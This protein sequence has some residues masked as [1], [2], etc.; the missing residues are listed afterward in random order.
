M[1]F[2]SPTAQPHRQR[3]Q[4]IRKLCIIPPLTENLGLKAGLK[5]SERNILKKLGM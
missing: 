5:V 2:K 4:G 1:H 3:V